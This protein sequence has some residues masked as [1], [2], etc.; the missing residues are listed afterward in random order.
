MSKETTDFQPSK[1]I[2]VGTIEIQISKSDRDL[3]HKQTAP[4]PDEGDQGW[5]ALVST[6]GIAGVPPTHE[7]MLVT[8]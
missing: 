2:T 4:L 8:S 7:I 5:Q 1:P 3:T 6:P